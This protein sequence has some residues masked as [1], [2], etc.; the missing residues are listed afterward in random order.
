MARHLVQCTLPH[1]NPGDVRVWS[2]RNGNL[3]LS[4]VPGVDGETGDS[5]GYPYGTLPRLLLFWIV[6]EATV[7]KSRKLYLGQSLAQFMRDVG[8]NPDNGSGKRSDS[9]RLRHAMS[10]LFRATISFDI[11]AEVGTLRGKGWKSMQ[12]APEGMFWWDES[13]VEQGTLWQSWIELGEKF[14]EA[15]IDGPVPVQ[16]EA[17]RLLKGSSLELDLYAGL[18]TAFHI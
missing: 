11:R 6:R 1:S 9:R 7:K 10:S 12:V 5:F 16:V 8:L 18:R 3:T 15:I 4:I 14:Y 17:L 2:R 13:S